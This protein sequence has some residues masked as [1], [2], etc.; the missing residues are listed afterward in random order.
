MQRE[1]ESQKLKARK[2]KTM[3][4][5]SRLEGATWTGLRDAGNFMFFD[6]SKS[7]KLTM[8]TAQRNLNTCFGRRWRAG[9]QAVTQW[10]YTFTYLAL[11]S[12]SGCAWNLSWRA[13]EGFHFC[14][15]S[16]FF[17]SA[18]CS[19]CR[20]SA[21]LRLI[22]GC[23]QL[24]RHR[25]FTAGWPMGMEMGRIGDGKMKDRMQKQKKRYKRHGNYAHKWTD[26]KNLREFVERTLEKSKKTL[27]RN[28]K[29]YVD[30]FLQNTEAMCHLLSS[31]LPRPLRSNKRA[32]KSGKHF[33]NVCWFLLKRNPLLCFCNSK[34]VER[35][36]CCCRFSFSAP[37]CF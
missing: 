36:G 23:K 13:C 37:F 6:R 32:R 8:L 20:S 9:C 11:G 35:L 4:G 34:T 5:G 16:L 26:L 14:L 7:R 27:E 28:W 29:N 21:R 2:G 31:T 19:W 33:T 30:L 10:A 25:N 18:A 24:R 17:F 3:T 22:Q 1:V 15:L 12:N